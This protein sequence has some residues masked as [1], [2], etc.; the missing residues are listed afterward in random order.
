MFKELGNSLFAF[1]NFNNEAKKY[2]EHVEVGN[3]LDSHFCEKVLRSIEEK[4]SA[5]FTYGGWMEDRSFLWKGSYLEESG[6][7]IHLGSDF[8]VPYG[9]RVFAQYDMEVVYMENDFPLNH[10][11]GQML[12][13]YIKERNICI[14]YGHLSKN[15]S[16]KIADKISKDEIIGIVG[17]VEE[18]GFWFPHLHVQVITKK[19]FDEVQLRNTWNEFDGYGL[20]NDLENLVK[21]YKDPMNYVSL[22]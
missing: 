6:N 10:G 15:I 12:I 7:F 18:N 11:W 3:L 9:T 4:Y 17:G 14:L 22:I 21:I 20:K 5:D 13:G 2:I 8:N 1:V 16:W 19:Y